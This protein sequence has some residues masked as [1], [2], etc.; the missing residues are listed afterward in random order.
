MGPLNRLKG[1]D[2]KVMPTDDEMSVSAR[3]KKYPIGIDHEKREQVREPA[4]KR[5]TGSAKIAGHHY[6]PAAQNHP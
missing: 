1:F 4:R 6:R 5:S 2:A 3:S